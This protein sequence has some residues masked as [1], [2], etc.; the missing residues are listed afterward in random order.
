[1][2]SE[3]VEANG[4]TVRENNLSE[5]HTIALGTLVE[6][7][8][9]SED[10]NMNGVRMFVV[11]HSRDCDGTPLYDLSA[12]RDAEKEY[13]ESEQ[14]MEQTR[15]QEQQLAQ[16]VHWMM[17]GRITRHWSEDSLTIV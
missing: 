7:K 10:E 4:K 11:N 14:E 6:V 17:K 15:G 8:D 5:M 12:Y 1:M 13:K 16:L 9:D 3:I 2:V